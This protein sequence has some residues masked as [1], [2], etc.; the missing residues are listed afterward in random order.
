MEDDL[1]IV[2][3]LFGFLTLFL[4]FGWFSFRVSERD[5]ELAISNI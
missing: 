3:Q 5:L 4:D 1:N 2:L